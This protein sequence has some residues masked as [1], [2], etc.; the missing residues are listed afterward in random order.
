MKLHIITF[1]LRYGSCDDGPNSWEFRRVAVARLLRE[2]DADVVCLQEVLRWQYD[3]LLALLE[4]R[5]VGVFVGRDDGRDAGESC[6]IIY[7]RSRIFCT[8]SPEVFWLSD[9][10]DVAG[11]V[12]RSWGNRLPRMCLALHLLHTPTGCGFHVFNTHLDHESPAA[13]KRGVDL[14]LTRVQARLAAVASGPRGS[15]PL[16]VTGDLNEGPDGL[17]VKAL[18]GALLDALFEVGGP[19]SDARGT[20]H[21]WTGCD[22][23]RPSHID[24]IFVRGFKVDSATVYT[25]RVQGRLPSD[26]FPVLAVIEWRGL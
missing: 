26:H 7:Q 12:S 4:G 19:A 8:G 22:L 18:R 6:A 3:E 11:S 5:W 23:G 17:G 21:D 25:G 1:N 14:I 10:P 20:L 24:Y 15:D 16:I 13:R 2:L 9:T